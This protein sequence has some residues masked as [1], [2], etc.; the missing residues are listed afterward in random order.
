M[1][2]NKRVTGDKTWGKLLIHRKKAQA[3]LFSSTFGFGYQMTISSMPHNSVRTRDLEKNARSQGTL[4]A[5]VL[6][7]GR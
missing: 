5:Q 2:F 6:I 3:P 4:Y 7:L 1:I